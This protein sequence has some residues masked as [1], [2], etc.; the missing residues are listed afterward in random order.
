MKIKTDCIQ[1]EKTKMIAHVTLILSHI[2]YFSPRSCGG[3]LTVQ[4]KPSMVTR[5][6]LHNDAI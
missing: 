3:V 1:A 4:D 6:D 5:R 2:C